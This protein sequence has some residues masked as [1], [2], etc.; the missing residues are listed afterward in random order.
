MESRFDDLPRT[1]GHH[2]RLHYFATVAHVLREVV[3]LFPSEDAA[4]QEFPFLKGYRD[5]IAR[6]KAIT[7][8]AFWAEAISQWERT[9]DGH[10]PLRALRDGAEL[11][12]RT[13]SLL[14]CIG[15]TE[16]DG[17]FGLLFEALQSTPGVHRPTMGLL[18][19]WW[20]EPSDAGEVRA[21]LRR[22]R[23]LGLTRVV[24]PDA[25]RVEWALEPLGPLWDAL[26][27][28]TP[29]SPANWLRFTPS[30]TLVALDAVVVP[31]H[32]AQTV[33]KL[34]ALLERGEVNALVVR[35]PHRGGRRVLCGAL[36]KLLGRGLLEVTD[37][38]AEPDQRFRAA[39]T[40]ATLLQA[41]PAVVVD[42]GPGETVTL[43][44]WAWPDASLAVVMGPQGGIAGPPVERS[45]TLALPMP[46]PIERVRHWTKAGNFAE[47]DRDAIAARFRM[48]SGNIH[49]AARLAHSY[50]AL[51]GHERPGLAEVQQASRALNRQALDT[52]ALR[53][54][55]SGDWSQLAISPE[56]QR[57]LCD[58]ERRCRHR[59]ELAGLVGPSLGAQLRPGVRALLQ[60]PSGT[61]KTLAARLLASVLHADLYR[62]DLAS[63]VNKYIGETEKN[64]GRIFS[65]AE[66]LDVMLLLDEGDALLARR[67]AVHTANDRYAN[68]ETNYLLQRIESFEGI[69][70]LTTNAHEHIDRAFQRRMDVV[71]EFRVP[72]AAERWAIWQLHLPSDHGVELPLLRE[73]AR[74]CQMTGGQIRNAVLHAAMLAL[75]AGGPMRNEH[76][77]A[78]VQREYRKSGAVYP[79]RRAPAA[80]VV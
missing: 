65:L 54:D 5:E 66:E 33:A 49:R 23:D 59:E 58:L 52:L 46:D 55:A 57:E 25:P 14:I 67:T 68:L 73:L 64:L 69:V 80:Q 20:R 75:E 38:G 31:E 18:N 30:E 11:D 47:A 12:H 39:G 76:V 71:V 1:P 77:E 48:T 36:A 27:G 19:A 53:L 42:P 6:R 3:S 34:P 60:G 4:L 62:V 26:R 79:L 21:A 37:L 63:V 40:L 44:A 41:L 45:L 15:L 35:G 32:V 22:L 2:F 13:L 17:R 29:H 72:D 70:L 51:A 24:N 8:P 7:T 56:T 74:R 16:E 28:E 61:G 9:A 78:S 50:A 43:P 10:L